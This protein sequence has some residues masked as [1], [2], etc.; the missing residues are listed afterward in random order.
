MKQ[1]IITIL[2]AFLGLMIGLALNLEGWLGIIFAIAIVG[3]FIVEAI[4]KKKQ[5]NF[6]MENINLMMLSNPQLF[7]HAKSHSFI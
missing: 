7:L 1:F 4:E 2:V 6:I 3:V 5:V